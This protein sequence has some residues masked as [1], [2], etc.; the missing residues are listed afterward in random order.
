MGRRSGGVPLHRR[1]R[2]ASVAVA[3]L[4]VLLFAVPLAVTVQRL[5]REQLEARLSADATRVAALVPDSAP[6]RVDLA[7]LPAPQTDA[8]VVG[9]YDAQ[10]RRVA[11]R[12]PAQSRLARA[13]R[14][15]RLHAGDESRNIAVVAPVP[16]DQQVSGVVRVAVSDGSLASRVRRT[17]LAMLGLALL[18]LAVAA[19]VA[20]RQ[21]RRIAAPISDLADAARQLGAG[22][23]TIRPHSAG[24]VEV[25]SAGAAL[26]Q[27]A[28][29]LGALVERQRR[30]AGDASH[31]L[32]TPLAGLLLGLE[33]ALDRPDADLRAAV[34]TAVTRADQLRSTV[35]ELLTLAR[36]GGGAQRLSVS[37]VLLDI[38]ARWEPLAAAQRRR[39]VLRDGGRTLP[40]ARGSALAVRSALDVLVDNALRHGTGTITVGAT[41][42]GTALALEVA[43]EGPGLDGDPERF[44]GG[45]RSAATGAIGLGLA[46]ALLGADGGRLVVRRAAPA[47]VFAVL[48]PLAKA[49]SA[50]PVPTG[51]DG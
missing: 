32:R 9:V 19:T 45:D 22:D 42:L 3:A 30:F 8:A 44:F 1:V 37:G 4:A 28:E 25:D 49:T 7:R 50:D 47:P 35:D 12:G 48:L 34:R 40:D 51:V 15:G 41:D 6:S 31:Q 24:I 46:R 43:D 38:A 20:G 21:A 16:S 18:V 14:D 5:N 23:F 17:W 26:G 29:R 13:A 36:E 10:G 27:T 39:L 11:G 2:T 33:S